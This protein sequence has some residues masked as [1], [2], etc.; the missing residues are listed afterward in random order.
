[1][2]TA[3]HQRVI[4]A[5]AGTN[6]M[7]VCQVPSG[8]AVLADTQFLKGYT[9][10]LPDPVVPDLNSLEPKQQFRFLQDMAI[11]GDALME[12]TTA[13]R[14]NYEIL[15]N[16]T[17]ALYAHIIP[18][19]PGEPAERRQAAVWFYEKTFRNSLPFDLE[20]H[21]SLMKELKEAIQKRL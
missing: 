17:P 10:L 6:P 21:G 2:S 8:W 3:I 12:V 1:M 9:L 16:T 14:I 18:R 15:G 5:R 20:R 19:Y 11:I 4:D 7:A 13:C